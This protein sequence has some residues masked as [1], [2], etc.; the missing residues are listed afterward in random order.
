MQMET[1]T[2]MLDTRTTPRRR[3]HGHGERPAFTVECIED[4][5]S[6]AVLRPEWED[7]LKASGA[8]C[9]FL[10]WEWMAT[11][12]KHLSQGRRLAVLAVRRG[13]ELLAIAPLALKPPQ[14]G[15]L[16]PFR[17]LEFL[18]MGTVGSDY[19]DIIV[20]PDEE[21]SAL[22]ALAEYLQENKFVIEFT[23]VKPASRRITGLVSLLR[24]ARWHAHQQVVDNCPYIPLTGHTWESYMSGVS[25]PH[26]RNVRR[27]LKILREKFQQVEFQQVRTEEERR[28]CFQAFV[29]LHEKRWSG[30]EDSTAFTGPEVQ[31]FHEEF[32]RLA[33]EKGWLR[34]CLLKLD[35]KPVG[36]TYS[37]RYGDSYYYYQ[38]GYD[39]AYNEYSVGLVT[40]ALLV[41][42]AISEGAG[43]FDM[44]HGY[45]EYKFLW[46]RA[47]RDLARVRC[48][49]PNSAGLLCRSA[50]GLRESLKRMATWRWRL[51]E[52][53]A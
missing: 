24:Q 30:A 51:Q 12:W 7:L 10:T 49:P 31:A 42:T 19:L 46:T 16:L 11:W 45:E 14:F 40:L 39:P 25:G 47:G 52:A 17:V 23:R 34:L 44:L 15:R 53:K 18:G 9:L 27:R 28:E 35:G 37:F 4:T 3:N 50:L 41:Q 43:E 5:D 1:D 32:S 33:L 2:F 48:F 38:A 26:R 21:E 20:R 6:L 8:D 29:Q 36:S 13:D 22:K